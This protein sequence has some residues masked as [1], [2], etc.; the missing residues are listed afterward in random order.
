MTGKLWAQNWTSDPGGL[1]KA[2]SR[3]PVRGLSV[4]CSVWWKHHNSV[5]C[6]RD[7]IWENIPGVWWKTHTVIHAGKHT[8][9]TEAHCTHRQTHT[10]THQEPTDLW[11]GWKNT[12]IWKTFSQ[13][14]REVN[15]EHIPA[16][17]L[18]VRCIHLLLTCGGQM[19]KSLVGCRHI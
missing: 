11:F 14:H 18:N 3:Q 4:H 9:R 13:L 1:T 5:A 15:E 19:K 17:R 8:T 2:S 10:N 16:E 7:F 6:G 12:W